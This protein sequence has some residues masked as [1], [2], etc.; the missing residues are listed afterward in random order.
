MVDELGN[1]VVA[2]LSYVRDLEQSITKAHLV[3]H[4]AEAEGDAAGVER[5]M[6]HMADAGSLGVVLLSGGGFGTETVK[7]V[8]SPEVRAHLE[9]TNRRLNAL[10]PLAVQRALA[11][12]NGIDLSEEVDRAFND[13]FDALMESV[14]KAGKAE[15][16]F[17]AGTTADADATY[18]LWRNGLALMVLLGMGSAF[19]MAFLIGRSV[20]KPLRRMM[21]MVEG[22]QAG[23]LGSR[24]GLESRDEFGRLGQAL[25]DMVEALERNQA[26][27][28]ESSRALE[29]AMDEARSAAATAEERRAYLQTR[30]DVILEAMRGLSQGNLRA[31]LEAEGDDAIARLFAGFNDTVEHL[32]ELMGRVRGAA[33][34]ASATSARIR[35][36]SQDLTRASDS[37]STNAQNA[38]AASTQV[39]GSM[40]MVASAAEQMTGSIREISER[41]QQGLRVNRQAAER[42]EAAVKLVDELDASSRDIGEVVEVINAIA[43]QTNLLALNATIEAARAGEAGKGFAVVAS[44]VKQLATQTAKATEEIAGKIR[45]TQERTGATVEMIGQITRI[46]SEIET[47]SMTIAGAVEE[48]SAV[49]QDITRSV[50]EAAGGA[51]SVNRSVETVSTVAVDTATQAR[52][53]A[54]AAEE[55]SRVAGELEEVVGRFTV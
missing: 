41:L 16:A 49:T 45:G 19:A 34:A 17:V 36:A 13:S 28:Q 32:R 4:E 48:Q 9:E 52:H 10:Q 39:N 51:E 6:G 50:A 33:E 15:R 30:V 37:T 31:H 21:T 27:I 38:M 43:E 8:T 14:A 1:D 44:E 7:A 23:D 46:M 40:Q 22:V 47:L 35:S 55:L 25:D 3:L 54:G 53:T 20:S 29:G 42:A 5:A 11:V 2:E 18:V 24:T 12:K 26:E